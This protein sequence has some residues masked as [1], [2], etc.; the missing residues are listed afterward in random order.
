MRRR[1]F[2]VSTA[3]LAGALISP[4]SRGQSAPCPPSLVSAVGG[5]ATEAQC[6]LAALEGAP[7]WFEAMPELHWTAVATG[8]GAGFAGGKRIAD[9]RYRHHD[10]KCPYHGV[11]E[12][13][14]YYPSG[15]APAPNVLSY[16]GA[17][18]NQDT[19]EML[20]FGGG[21][22][23]YAGNEVYAL[24]LRSEVPEWRCLNA[25]SPGALCLDP[26]NTVFAK[27]SD[28]RYGVDRTLGLGAPQ[29]GHSYYRLVW[30]PPG[31]MW[32]MATG[33]NW[34]DNPAGGSGNLQTSSSYFYF[35][36]KTN[37]WHRVGQWMPEQ[38]RDYAGLAIHNAGRGIY[39]PERDELWTS[40]EFNYGGSE[41]PG[42]ACISGVSGAAPTHRTYPK[43]QCL[44]W[45]FGAGLSIPGRMFGDRNPLVLLLSAYQ[46]W[47]DY[48]QPY[49]FDP[50]HPGQ[51]N[52]GS[53]YQSVPKAWYKK[54][55]VKNLSGL[56]FSSNVSSNPWSPRFQGFAVW[57]DASSSVLIGTG[58]DTDFFFRL[59]PPENGNAYT[60][61]WTLTRV[62]VANLT[63]AKRTKPP[64]SVTGS[65]EHGAF[66]RWN[67]V[68]DMGN[69]QAALVYLPAAGQAGSTYVMK[70][71]RSGA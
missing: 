12:G 39:V 64:N 44:Q 71:P 24:S 70:L 14:G 56:E 66:N 9:A 23:S 16:G 51:F 4:I 46:Q 52:D 62:F 43:S 55:S 13:R 57:H 35:D 1:E 18:V 11:D 48:R 37:V 15:T 38:F 8:A 21:H 65:T 54:V 7:S 26:A 5:S 67:I 69:G 49:L 31:R 63:D 19:G 10:T 2:L 42:V 30:T 3:G 36:T 22:L 20:A 32:L 50:S 33:T 28:G 17:A 25:P 6:G 40:H 34:N 60:G 41:F 47:N 53:G 29:V 61:E 45:D 59:S 58:W 27:E 68:H